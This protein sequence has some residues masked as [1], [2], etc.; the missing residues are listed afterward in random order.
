MGKK[1]WN[2]FVWIVV[3]SLCWT[4]C[5]GCFLNRLFREPHPM[6]YPD[7]DYHFPLD[8]AVGDRFEPLQDM[9]LFKFDN[10]PRHDDTELWYLSTEGK[11]AN[12]GPL[13]R[14]VPAG[15]V[16]EIMAI[17]MTPCQKNLL[18]Y[19]R[20]EGGEEWVINFLFPNEF[21]SDKLGQYNR[22]LF[23]KVPM[24]VPPTTG[25]DVLESNESL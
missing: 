13:K 11:D 3:T 14:I 21:W 8:F 23:R 18:V 15:E 25:N 7:F 12:A 4:G 22:R 16:C 20:L 19:L 2:P 24:N 17:K 5:S 1:H 6:T 10:L 9:Y